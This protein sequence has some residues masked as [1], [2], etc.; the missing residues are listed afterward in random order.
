MNINSL[1]NEILVL[2]FQQL[3]VGSRL[4]AA[5]VCRKWKL[6]SERSWH[7]CRDVRMTLCAQDRNFINSVLTVLYYT[8]PY[9]QKLTL[10]GLV[11]RGDET[12]LNKFTKCSHVVELQLIE[13]YFWHQPEFFQNTFPNLHTIVVDQARPDLDFLGTFVGVRRLVLSNI[14]WMGPTSLT[15]ITT[16][17]I[18]L[19]CLFMSGWF[20]GFENHNDITYCIAKC[21]NLKEISLINLGCGRTNHYQRVFYIQ[22]QSGMRAVIESNKNLEYLHFQRCAVSVELMNVIVNLE[23]LKVLNMAN[24]SPYDRVDEKIFNLRRS[25]YLNPLEIIVFTPGATAAQQVLQSKHNISV[26]SIR[27]T[28]ENRLSKRYFNYKQFV[29][30]TYDSRA[31]CKCD[32]HNAYYKCGRRCEHRYYC[33]SCLD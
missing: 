27:P 3:D 24:S 19:E 12:T 2:I 30:F 23:N 10:G 29:E 11:I 8:S 6:L 13:C 21:Q 28:H 25:G 9:L 1:P 15:V 26:V 5:E 20:F 33:M 17:L 22:P 7:K 16:G 31:R 4:Q 32:L 14:D 18:N